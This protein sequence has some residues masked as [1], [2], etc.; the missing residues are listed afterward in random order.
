[1]WG[2]WGIDIPAEF[3]YII[4][5]LKLFSADIRI[6]RIYADDKK[7]GWITAES[8]K[9]ASKLRLTVTNTDIVKCQQCIGLMT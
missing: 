7:F 8:P 3:F 6:S 5:R 9:L 1:M 2:Q 4:D